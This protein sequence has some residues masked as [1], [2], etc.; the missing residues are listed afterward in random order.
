MVGLVGKLDGV[1]RGYENPIIENAAV[2]SIQTAGLPTRRN[3]ADTIMTASN[4]NQ[5]LAMTVV[6]RQ[7][8]LIS[9]RSNQVRTMH[10][11]WASNVGRA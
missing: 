2:R 3:I 4:K 7:L 11:A 1:K 8:T 5:P 6:V 9:W 10:E